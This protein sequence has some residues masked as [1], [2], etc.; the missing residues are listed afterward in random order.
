MLTVLHFWDSKI[1]T[2]SMIDYGKTTD[3][4]EFQFEKGEFAKSFRFG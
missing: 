1:I 2:E 3:P 4:F